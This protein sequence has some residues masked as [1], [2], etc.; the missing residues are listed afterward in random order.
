MSKWYLLSGR[1]Q[2][3][4]MSIIM[5]TITAALAEWVR[6]SDTLTKFEATV[7]GRS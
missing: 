3:R 4:A 2:L 1:S 5:F 7:C 6:A